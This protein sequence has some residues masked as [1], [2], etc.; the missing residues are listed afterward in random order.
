MD[1][2]LPVDQGI[3]RFH[4]Y[5]YCYVPE[6]GEPKGEEFEIEAEIL[7]HDSEIIRVIPNWR[8]IER[9]RLPNSVKEIRSVTP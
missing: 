5:V 6:M 4:Y 3:S 7:G 2:G 9:G 1:G 8:Y